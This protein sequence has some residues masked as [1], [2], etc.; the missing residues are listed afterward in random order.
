MVALALTGI[1]AGQQT[2]EEKR[3]YEDY[4]RS[5]QQAVAAFPDL[6]NDDTPLAKKVAEMDKALAAD[7]DPLYNSADKPLILTRRAA[8]E[9]RIKPL[10]ANPIP[11]PEPQAPVKL[12]GQVI[13]ELNG[14]TA[15]TIRSVEPDGLRIIHESGASKIP[16]EKLTEEQ[17]AKYGLTVEGAAQYRKRLAENA[18]SGYARQQ[19][20]ANNQA[21]TARNSPAAPAAKFITSDQVK[22]MWVK[23]LPQPRSL[24]ANYS[25]IMK[26]YSEFIGEIRAGKRDLD[27]QETAATYNKSKAIETGNTELASTYEAELGRIAQAKSAAAE[28]AQREKQARRERVDFMMLNSQLDSIDR[29]LRNIHNTIQGW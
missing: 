3:F 12:D 15:V 1:C 16:I 8:K 2:A 9:L 24:D 10:E 14:Y 5:E 7:E 21:A 23:R 19:E 27:A 13:P 17:R 22:I 29:N 28:L 25:K 4:A 26:S 11:M 18:A 6:G 20:A